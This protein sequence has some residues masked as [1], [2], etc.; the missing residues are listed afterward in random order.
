MFNQNKLK[1]PAASFAAVIG[2][3]LLLSA[4]G[5]GGT[6]TPEPDPKPDP[7]PTEQVGLIKGQITPFKMGDVSSV[8]AGAE[9]DKDSVIAQAPV[10]TSGKFDLQLPMVTVITSNFDNKL[11]VPKYVFGCDDSQIDKESS[12]TPGLRLLPIND[13]KTDKFQSIIAEIDPNSQTFNYK[14]WYFANMDGN[15]KFKGDCLLRGKID[16]NL[17]FKRGWNVVN[18]F[19]DTNAGTT[20]YAI[21]SQPADRIPWKFATA[22]ANSLSL[23]GQSIQLTE[24]YFTPWLNLPQYQ[25]R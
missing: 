25:N 24:N 11:V 18:T 22:A 21:T 23:R 12:F 10:D 16:T 14:A 15:L 5:G 7:K 4:C 1:R 19:T 20:T 2:L 17:S 3:S 9:N 13:L 8:S 6:V